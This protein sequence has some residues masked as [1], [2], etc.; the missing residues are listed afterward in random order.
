MLVI[1]DDKNN[2]FRVFKQ[3]LRF[4]RFEEKNRRSKTENHRA[5]IKKRRPNVIEPSANLIARRAKPSEPA[6]IAFAPVTMAN[7]PRTITFEPV[8]IDFEP[9]AIVFEPVAIVFEPVAI[10]FELVAIVF[11]PVAI[12]FAPRAIAFEPV[13]ITFAPRKIGFRQLTKLQKPRISPN[14]HGHSPEIPPKLENFLLFKSQRFSINFSV[15]D[16][17][18]LFSNLSVS[19]AIR[20]WDFSYETTYETLCFLTRG[21]I[22]DLTALILVV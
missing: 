3:L 19:K 10:V 15:E 11:E 4:F 16:Q 20:F 18:K 1:F 12:T 2:K 21:E 9:V 17:V 6:A 5:N 22:K 14:K 13:A 7:A 8:A